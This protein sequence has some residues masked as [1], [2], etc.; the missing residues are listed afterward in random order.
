MLPFFNC[1]AA[2][3]DLEE[4]YDYGDEEGELPDDEEEKD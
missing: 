3:D 4:D 1:Y 2:R